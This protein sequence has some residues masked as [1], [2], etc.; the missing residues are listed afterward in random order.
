[1]NKIEGKITYIADGEVGIKVIALSRQDNGLS[2]FPVGEL[3]SSVRNSLKY[4][5]NAGTPHVP[6]CS[7]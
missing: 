7:A 1:M 2:T 3:S 4:R 5:R 6:V